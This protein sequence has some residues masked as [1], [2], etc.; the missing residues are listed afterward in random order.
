M[1]RG[2]LILGF[3]LLLTLPGLAA[4]AANAPKAAERVPD[5][6]VTP[7]S[8]DYP[9]VVLESVILD[10]WQLRVGLPPGWIVEDSGDILRF[11]STGHLPNCGISL[12]EEPKLTKATFFETVWQELATA[13]GMHP[14]SAGLA[15]VGNIAVPLIW[16]TINLAA[17]EPVSFRQITA[18]Y[19]FSPE[20]YPF[21]ATASVPVSLWERAAPEIESILGHIETLASE[22]DAFADLEKRPGS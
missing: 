4:P 13:Q 2:W 20:E 5:L 15:K 16:A 12:V 14:Q 11:R 7:V 6:V 21:I 3:G 18:F 10:E 8:L 22:E 19:E 1:T 9:D 17:E